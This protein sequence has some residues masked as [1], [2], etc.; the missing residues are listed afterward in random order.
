M[1]ISALLMLMLQGCPDPTTASEL[2]HG[3]AGAPGSSGGASSPGK[4]QGPPPAPGSFQVDEGTGVTISGTLAYEGSQTGVF[5]IDFLLK[6]ADA[7]PTLAHM[8]ELDAP[9]PFSVEAPEGT[10]SLYVVGFVDVKGDG[11]SASDPAGMLEVPIV[12]ESSPIADLVL[13]L[14]DAPEL[15]DF[16]PGDHAVVPTEGPAGGV[17][18]APLDAPPAPEEAPAEPEEA[19]AEPE[20]APAEPEEA[21]A[22]PEEAPAEPD[23]APTEAPSE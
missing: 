13:T 1:S 21:P 2:G 9:G 3:P 15:G 7:P 16:T 20:E 12:V 11:P 4:P 19:P 18:A 10:G 8:L 22:E 14:S 17:K 6:E 23:E 5:R